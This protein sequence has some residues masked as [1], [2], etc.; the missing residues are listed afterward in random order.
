M[1]G[2]AADES[3]RSLIVNADDFGQS[4]GINQGVAIAHTDGIVTSASMMVR[5]PAVSEAVVWARAREG[6]SL[7]LHLDLGEW[8]YDA[9]TFSW[10]PVYEVVPLDDATLIYAEVRAQCDRFVELSTSTCANQSAPSSS[11]KR[12][13]LERP[14]GRRPARPVIR[15][16]FTAKA[17]KAGRCPR[18]LNRRR[19]L[20]F[21]RISL[22]G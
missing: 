13:A 5:W 14:S 4:H 3:E 8:R 16:H 15:G 1:K 12:R 7:G 6:F 2:S 11:R 17:A 20:P 18:P 19:S 22:Q 21:W 10:V 9:T